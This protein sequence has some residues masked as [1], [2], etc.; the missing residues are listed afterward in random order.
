MKGNQPAVYCD[1]PDVY[2]RRCAACEADMDG[3]LEHG[4]LVCTLIRYEVDIPERALVPVGV[5]VFCGQCAPNLV[6]TT[7]HMP[8]HT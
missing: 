3:H 7:V 2:F 5:E 4:E 6:A 1:G 8:S